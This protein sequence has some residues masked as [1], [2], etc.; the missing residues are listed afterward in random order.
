MIFPGRQGAVRETKVREVV[1]LRWTPL[2]M[3][4]SWV[5]V[6]AWIGYTRGLQDDLVELAAL[7]HQVFDGPDTVVPYGTAETSVLFWRH[8]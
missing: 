2:E 1:S 7:R 8:G 3:A 6:L 4:G 5:C